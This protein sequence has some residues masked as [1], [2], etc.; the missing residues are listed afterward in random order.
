MRQFINPA[1]FL[2]AAAT[3]PAILSR[4]L[5][6]WGL[7]LGFQSWFF[8]WRTWWATPLEPLLRWVCLH[9]NKVSNCIISVTVKVGHTQIERS[10]LISLFQPS[11]NTNKL[12]YW[13]HVGEMLFL[14]TKGWVDELKWMNGLWTCGH[15][16]QLS[17]SLARVHSSASQDAIPTLP[18]QRTWLS[19]QVLLLFLPPP[20]PY[21]STIFFSKN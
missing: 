19:L 7:S 2:L 10:I 8:S 18:G 16:L 1:S 13:S 11:K 21:P 5:F 9:C 6:P 15:F 12:R 4:P 3:C 14:Y 20:P 17:R